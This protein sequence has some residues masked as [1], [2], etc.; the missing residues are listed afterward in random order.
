MPRGVFSIA[1]IN[2]ESWQPL[3]SKGARGYPPGMRCVVPLRVGVSAIL[4]FSLIILGCGKPPERDA[5]PTGDVNAPTRTRTLSQLISYAEKEGAE[6]MYSPGIASTYGLSGNHPTKHLLY[7]LSPEPQF[8]FRSFEVIYDDSRRPI[9]LLWTDSRPR[10]LNSPGSED[11]W[12]Y[13]S[14]MAGEL[15]MV[16]H[17]IDRSPS[18]KKITDTDRA[19]YRKLV[20][21][22]LEEAT[23]LKPRS[24]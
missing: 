15:E 16:V 14:S 13:K 10:A 3:D 9:A 24:R 12:E 20:G 22:F 11:S 4:L 19:A 21:F 23:M 8:T 1:K 2:V 17:V 7:E 18:R 5:R 6:G